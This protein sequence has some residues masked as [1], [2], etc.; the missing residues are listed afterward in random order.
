[1]TLQA[2]L[3]AAALALVPAFARAD[4]A[5]KT[6]TKSSS[7]PVDTSTTAKADQ[8][9]P[10]QPA[11]QAQK[12]DRGSMDPG[13]KL[14]DDQVLRKVHHINL[15]EIDAGK[16]AQ[17]KGTTREVKDYGATLVRDHTKADQDTKTLASK[18]NVDLE[19]MKDDARHREKQQA[20]QDKMDQLKKMTGKEFDRT[21]A[22]MM[23]DGHRQA[24]EMVKTARVDAKP[25]LKS[26]LDQ[27]LPVLQ[28]HEDMANAILNKSRDTASTK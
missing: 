9:D 13:K 24:I 20:M 26:F 5:K 22:Q 19:K 6:D 16:L 27:L 17:Q 15:E 28:K 1:M 21:F 8:T 10:S 3:L 4:D 12:M 23:A 14:T 7:S 11:S 18:M 2:T 25:E